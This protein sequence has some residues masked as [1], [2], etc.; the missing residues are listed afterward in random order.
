MPVAADTAGLVADT[1]ENITVADSIAELVVPDSV[2]LFSDTSDA[3]TVVVSGKMSEAPDSSK[4]SPD[5][6]AVDTVS[7][8]KIVR[9]MSWTFRQRIRS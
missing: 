6:A 4:V 1:L 3:D 5:S 8:G 7:R 2:K 9:S